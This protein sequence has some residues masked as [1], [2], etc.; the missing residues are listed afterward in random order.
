[1][2]ASKPQRFNGGL[3]VM[4]TQTTTEENSTSILIP[5]PNSTKPWRVA[6]VNVAGDGL[7]EVV[8][9]DG[10][11]G[12]V[13]FTPS[14]FEGV[15]QELRDPAFFKQVYVDRG[16]VTWPGALDLA[17]DAMYDEIKAHGEW[18]LR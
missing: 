18:V 8:F 9:L 12:T 14:F 2:G 10:L 3:G 13:R 16:V 6:R 4:F 5:K 11:S 15:F 1:M 7:L 17:P